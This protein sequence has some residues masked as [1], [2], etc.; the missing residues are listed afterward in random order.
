MTALAPVLHPAMAGALVS[1]KERLAGI[2]RQAYGYHYSHLIKILLR[3]ALVEEDLGEWTVAGN[4][5]LNG[6]TYLEQPNLGIKMKV[7]K[8]NRRVH[9]GGVPPAGVTKSQ[10]AHYKDPRQLHLDFPLPE[11]KWPAGTPINLHLLWDHPAAEDGK[12]DYEAFT[13]RAV[14]TTAPSSFGKVVPLDLSFEILASDTVFVRSRFD[15]D[16]A[17]E[18]LFAFELDET[19]EAHVH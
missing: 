17:D 10:K 7:G 8:E 15:G 1:T 5:R 16:V 18:D 11:P 13:L 14:H 6:Q 9:P 2:D 3:E 12:L 4:S 19:E